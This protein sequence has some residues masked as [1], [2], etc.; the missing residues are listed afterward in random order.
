VCGSFRLEEICKIKA[1]VCNACRLPAAKPG[2]IV[3]AGTVILEIIRSTSSILLISMTSIVLKGEPS[4]REPDFLM[5]QDKEK[6]GR[7]GGRE[8][9]ST[10]NS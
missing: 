8:G 2:R 3:P 4:K 9:E 5:D 6:Q 1:N 10:K 7:E